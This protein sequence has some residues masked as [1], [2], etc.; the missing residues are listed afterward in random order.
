MKR[1]TQS[2]SSLL[3]NKK[4]CINP[5]QAIK[6]IVVMSR[7]REKS[8]II[9]IEKTEMRH[10]V[11]NPSSQHIDNIQITILMCCNLKQSIS[12]NNMKRISQH[13]RK[14]GWMIRSSS[15]NF[16]KNNM[17]STNTYSLQKLINSQAH[18]HKSV[19]RREEMMVIINYA[20]INFIMGDSECAWPV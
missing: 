4:N 3:R 8:R 12:F 14:I 9:E 11:H 17:I 5:K 1:R 10:Q 7:Q 13:S 20:V 19:K 2:S 16:T 18:H 6:D 15:I